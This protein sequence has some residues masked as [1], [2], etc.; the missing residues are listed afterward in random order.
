MRKKEDIQEYATASE[1]ARLW[2]EKH[3]RFL[4]SDYISKMA[5]S[6]RHHIRTIKSG[7][8]TLYHRADVIG[9]TIRERK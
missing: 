2:T 4:R 8:A 1:A 9:C 5:N 6:K 7:N 3:G